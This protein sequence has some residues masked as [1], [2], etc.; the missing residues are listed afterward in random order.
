MEYVILGLLMHANQTIYSI[1]KMF[2]N[3]ISLF[4]HA[5]YGSLQ[6]TLKKLEHNKLINSFHVTESGRNKKY[7][8]MTE[9][10]REY[11]ISWMTADFK[12]IKPA[13]FYTKIFFMGYV[14]DHSTRMMMTKNMLDLVKDSYERLAIL[15]HQVSRTAPDISLQP[16]LDSQLKMLDLGMKTTQVELIW[17]EAWLQELKEGLK[18]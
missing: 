7:Y 2:Q 16:L 17:L 11:F 12:E 3:I 15:N 18:P 5:S 4:Y 8:Q 13:H 1:N 9:L 6:T 10:G 14:I